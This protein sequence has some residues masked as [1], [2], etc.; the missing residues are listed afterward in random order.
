MSVYIYVLSV[1]GQ[2]V[3]MYKLTTRKL[4]G[5]RDIKTSGGQRNRLVLFV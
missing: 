1:K 2:F 3:G 4:I 5:R